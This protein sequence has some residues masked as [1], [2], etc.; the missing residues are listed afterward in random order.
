MRIDEVEQLDEFWGQNTGKFG[1][2]S[3]IPFTGAKATRVAVNKA[4]NL[5]AAK[6]KKF[7]DSN[8]ASWVAKYNSLLQSLPKAVAGRPAPVPSKAVVNK[9]WNEF[10]TKALGGKV[11]ATRMPTVVDK[12]DGKQVFA[13]FTAI[14]N[15]LAAGRTKKTPTAP[16]ITG[17][18]PD[19][20]PSTGGTKVTITGSGFT[21]VTQV[22]FNTTP[23]TNLVVSPRGDSITV[24]TPPAVAAGGAITVTVTSPAGAATTQFTYA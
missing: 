8:T 12:S 13:F 3:Y 20:G 19:T 23:G 2:G 10:V 24:E 11:L 9:M 15:A 14:G 6:V 18:T 4:A 22:T 16:S 21:G 5:N 7:A 1:A 17:I